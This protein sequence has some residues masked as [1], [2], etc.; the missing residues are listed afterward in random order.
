MKVEL[1]MYLAE[2]LGTFAL[3]FIGA[4]TVCATALPGRLPL[5]VA[6]VA[7]AEGCAYAAILSITFLVS[8]GCLNPGITLTLWVLR[9]LEIRATLA[10]IAAQV[11]GAAL[12]GLALR[13]VFAEEVLRETHLGT[14]HLGE[15]LL[16]AQGRIT[17]GGLVLG[18]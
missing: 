14:P 6:G 8:A 16:D 2:L 17:L 9:R 15:M 1:R 7:L 5:G 12:A 11:I 10:L 4:G 18:G 13:L 3:V